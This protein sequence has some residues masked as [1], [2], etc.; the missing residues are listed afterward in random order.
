[1][2]KWTGQSSRDRDEIAAAQ[3]SGHSEVVS[4]HMKP[5]TMQTVRATAGKRSLVGNKAST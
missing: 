1:V 4:L 2:Q 5:E 3:M